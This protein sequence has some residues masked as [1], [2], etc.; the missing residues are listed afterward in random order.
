MGGLFVGALILA[1]YV[2][3]QPGKVVSGGT[4]Q[5]GEVVE[6]RPF[7]GSAGRRLDNALDAND[8]PRS[9]T[10]RAEGPVGERSIAPVGAEE[11]AALSG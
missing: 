4:L 2:T 9:V 5:I 7:V 11:V 1:V 8:V 3:L 10:A 6:G